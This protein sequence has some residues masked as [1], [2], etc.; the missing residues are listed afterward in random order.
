MELHGREYAE[1]VLNK[2]FDAIGVV[3]EN[4]IEIDDDDISIEDDLNLDDEDVKKKDVLRETVIKA[5]RSKVIEIDDKN[6][7]VMT[8]HIPVK[9]E[10]TGKVLLSKMTF[11]TRYKG[12][13]YTKNMKGVDPKDM[14]GTIE[15]K[16]AALTETT[17]VLM[18]SMYN[19]DY[20]LAQAI[21]ILFQRAD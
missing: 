7:L 17:K 18:G 21:T 13:D 12:R 9:G 16:T 11:R 2:W 4:R 19:K 14:Y 15:A 20:D 10:K 5:I 6:Q 8:L 1:E 3:E